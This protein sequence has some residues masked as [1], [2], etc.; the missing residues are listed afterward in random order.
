MANSPAT[1]RYTSVAITLHWIIALLLGAMIGLGRNMHDA[2]HV[3]IEWMFQLHKSVG[4]TVL[5]L[6]IARLVWR[7][8]NRPPPLPAAMKQV[9]KRASHWVHIGLY[10]LV[11]A[12]PISGWI[13]VSVSPFAIATVLYGTIGWPHIAWLPELALETRQAIYPSVKNVHEIMS[14]A[15]IALFALHIVGAVKH[16]LSDEEGVMKRMIPGIFGKTT[17]PRAPARGALL[18]FGSAFAF[19]GMIAGGPVIAQSLTTEQSVEAVNSESNWIIDYTN[20]EIRFSGTHSGNDFSGIFE[21]WSASINFDPANISNGSATV[22]VA[23]QSAKTGDTLYDNTLNAVEW[24]SVSAFPN[25]TVALSNFRNDETDDNAMLADASLTI[26]DVT[27]TVP[28]GFRLEEINGV[29]TMTGETVLSR[30]AFNLGQE[31]DASA[32]WVGAEIAVSVIVKASP[33]DG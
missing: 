1:E 2:E 22:T 18:T 19:F 13:M 9:E 21:D 7:L 30:E 23:T 33:A 10:A 25:A 24:F 12:L 20:S 27:V 16:E 14:W 28:F 11:F 5:V 32:D 26:K 17:P 4:I 3:P 8:M 15:L 29:T 6:M 31:S